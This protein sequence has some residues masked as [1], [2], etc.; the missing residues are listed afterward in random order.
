MTPFLI[1]VRPHFHAYPELS[2]KEFESAKAISHH[3]TEAGIRWTRCDMETATL[4]VIE[5]KGSGKTVL[6]RADMDALPMTEKSALP[7][8]SCHQGICTP[9]VTTV[10]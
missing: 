1:D 7:Y 3:L 6:L 10:T 8:A 5:G 4:A 2:G 9:E